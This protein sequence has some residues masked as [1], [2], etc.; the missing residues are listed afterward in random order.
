VQRLGAGLE[1]L[2]LCGEGLV[3][4]LIGGGVVGV[5]LGEL[6]CDLLGDVLDAVEAVPDVLVEALD[7]VVAV[8]FGVLLLGR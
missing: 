8:V 5:D 1:L 3:V 2:D 7:V 4:L 6:V